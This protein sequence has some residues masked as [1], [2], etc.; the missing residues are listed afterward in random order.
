MTFSMNS[1]HLMPFSDAKTENKKVFDYKN[2]HHS[3]I[4][5][6]LAFSSTNLHAMIC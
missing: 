1:G 4:L 2:S 5:T 3:N 6:M